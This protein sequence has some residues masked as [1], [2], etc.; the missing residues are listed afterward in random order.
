MQRLALFTDGSEHHHHDW[1]RNP[2]RLALNFEGE[3]TEYDAEIRAC[4]HG[5]WCR[6]SGPNAGQDA[7]NLVYKKDCP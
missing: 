2:W 3:S 5:L 6:L 1:P 7:S 4:L